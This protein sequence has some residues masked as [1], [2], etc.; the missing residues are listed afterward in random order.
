MIKYVKYTCYYVKYPEET[1]IVD[2]LLY[3]WGETGIELL[4][5]DTLH[6]PGMQIVQF[7]ASFPWQISNITIAKARTND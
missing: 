7:S 4:P 1:Y 5:A 6:S 3:C 2:S